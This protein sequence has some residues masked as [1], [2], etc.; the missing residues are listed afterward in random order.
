M[1]GKIMMTGFRRW[2]LAGLVAAG[3]LAVAAVAS[4]QTVPAGMGTLSGKGKIK[5]KGCGHDKG[6]LSFFVELF[7]DGD[8]LI[9]DEDD[10]EYTGTSEQHGKVSE[11]TPDAG[12]LALIRSKLEGDV[13]DLCQTE[14]TATSIDLR[15]AQLKVSKRGTTAKLQMKVKGE[16]T[17]GEGSGKA[18]TQVKVDGDWGPLAT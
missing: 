11:L 15:K 4:A 8:W 10:T 18:S 12:S 6:E 3:T 14:V 13:S 2:T 1:E 9:I 5:A 7:T 17:S 16:G